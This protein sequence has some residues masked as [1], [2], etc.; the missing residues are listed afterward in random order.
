MATRSH[1]DHGLRTKH[2]SSF[3]ASCF[4]DGSVYVQYRFNPGEFGSV[5]LYPEGIAIS[6]CGGIGLTDVDA[7][8]IVT[9]AV[10]VWR[11][12]TGDET[13]VFTFSGQEINA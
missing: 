2:I 12:I 9:H 4:D 1:D 11:N 8:D 3:E 10:G 13:T 7:L 6:N 5:R